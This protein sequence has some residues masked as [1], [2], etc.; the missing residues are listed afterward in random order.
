MRYLNESLL[1]LDLGNTTC[2]I[3][4]WKNGKISKERI[5]PTHTFVNSE[6]PWLNEWSQKDGIAYCSVVPNAESSL[7]KAL[8]SRKLSP[9]SLTASTQS[10]LPIGYPKPEEIGADRIAN[11]IAVYQNFDL[12]AVVIDLGTATTFDVVTANGGYVGGVIIPGP[13]GML[14]FL[15]NNTALLPTLRLSPDKNLVDPIGKSTCGAIQSGLNFGYPAMLQGILNA[16]EE[17]L[18]QKHGKIKSLIQTGGESNHF[19]I[20]GSSICPYL[21]LEGLGLAFANQQV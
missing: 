2:K 11:A 14:D 8:V 19:Q 6:L 21:T 20:Q 15:G 10:I 5:I 16:L 4:I 17:Q 9:Y 1:C 7:L 18:E 3:G 12:P 13:Q